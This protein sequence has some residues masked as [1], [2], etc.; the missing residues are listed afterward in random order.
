M[1]EKAKKPSTS[2]QCDK[3]RRQA[4][5]RFHAKET[6]SVGDAAALPI[7]FRGEVGSLAIYDSEPNVFQ[8]KEIALLEEALS[9]LSLALE[10]LDREAER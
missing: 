9:A 2:P 5:E 3:F 10:G 1:V 8:E 7:Q 4:E 6:E